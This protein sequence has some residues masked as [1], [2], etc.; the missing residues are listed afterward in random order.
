MTESLDPSN[1]PDVVIY[2]LPEDDDEIITKSEVE[3]TREFLQA[4]AE[5]NL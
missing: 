5:A 2:I 1:A 4:Q 3:L